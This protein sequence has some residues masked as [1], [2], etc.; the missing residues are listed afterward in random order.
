MD[1]KKKQSDTAQR[2]ADERPTDHAGFFS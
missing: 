1:A 2:T